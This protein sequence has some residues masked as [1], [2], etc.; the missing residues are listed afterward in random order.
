MDPHGGMTMARQIITSRDIRRDVPT[1]GP[2]PEFSPISDAPP[3]DDAIPAVPDDYIGRLLKY[4]PTEVVA[5]YVTLTG[6]VASG[7]SDDNPRTAL[8][9]SIFALLLIGTPIYLARVEGVAK[10]QQ[11]LVSTVAFFVWVFALGGPFETMAAYDPLYGALLL[12]VFTFT[13]P[14]FEAKA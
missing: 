11:L 8:Y 6:M 2:E 1:S 14:I 12:P 5:L 4:V 9:W 13:I 3:S 10:K 7:R